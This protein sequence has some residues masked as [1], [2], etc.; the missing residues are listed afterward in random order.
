MTDPRRQLGEWGERRAEE[1]LRAQGYRVVERNWRC[2][3]GEVDLIAWE[4]E[5]L[6][7]VEVRTRRGRSYGTP[8]ESVTSAK[9]AKLIALAQMYMQGHPQ[10]RCNWRIDV[11]AVELWRTSKP[12]INLIRSAVMG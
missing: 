10:L 4:G 9:Q 5:Y 7:F 12:R 1:F 2:S 11:V 3:A 6:V 8:E